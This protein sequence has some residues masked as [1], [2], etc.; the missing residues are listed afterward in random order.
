[1][2]EQS[3]P[4]NQLCKWERVHTLGCG[5]EGSR[6]GVDVQRQGDA[7]VRALLAAHVLLVSSVPGERVVVSACGGRG[8]VGREAD[9]KGLALRSV[10]SCEG[11][12]KME[13]SFGRKNSTRR[14]A[15]LGG[16]ECVGGIGSERRQPSKSKDQSP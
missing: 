14:P 2:G 4:R 8:N 11:S 7:V 12:W 6:S 3:I 13:E 16:I 9:R 10:L 5:I 1:M 15:Q